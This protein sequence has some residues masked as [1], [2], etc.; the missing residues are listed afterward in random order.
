ELVRYLSSLFSLLLLEILRFGSSSALG[1]WFLAS[2]SPE[3]APLPSSAS[4]HP[5]AAVIRPL[6]QYYERI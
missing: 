2:C 4:A 5:Q 3:S 6:H 1:T